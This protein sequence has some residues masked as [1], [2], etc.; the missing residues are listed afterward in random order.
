MSIILCKR[1]T[2]YLNADANA[3]ADADTEML[4]LRFP[5]G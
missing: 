5:N 3:N 1:S 2:L 4:M